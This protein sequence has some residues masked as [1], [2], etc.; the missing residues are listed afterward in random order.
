MT[1]M[2]TL[3][4]ATMGA[5]SLKCRMAMMSAKHSTVRAVSA[6]LSPLETELLPA[7][8]KPMTCPPNSSMADSKLSRVRVEGS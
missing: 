8:E 7:S 3:C 2:D 1:G 4:A 6:T 5:P